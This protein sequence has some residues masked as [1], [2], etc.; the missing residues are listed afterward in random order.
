MSN[1]TK[2]LYKIH[3]QA[4]EEAVSGWIIAK[5]KQWVTKYPK[6]L[7]GNVCMEFTVKSVHFYAAICHSVELAVAARS[8]GRRR[9]SACLVFIPSATADCFT[10]HSDAV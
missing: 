7:K 5:S 9:S 2:L 8:D 6:I 1:K 3:K 10:N 4:F